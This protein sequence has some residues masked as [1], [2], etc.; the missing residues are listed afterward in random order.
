[1]ATASQPTDG[2]PSKDGNL[3]RLMDVLVS[4]EVVNGTAQFAYDAVQMLYP[5]AS[6]SLSCRLSLLSEIL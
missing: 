4:L 1:M 6:S 5:S 2:I 3:K